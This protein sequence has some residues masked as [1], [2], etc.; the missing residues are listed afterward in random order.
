MIEKR[1]ILKLFLTAL[2]FAILINELNIAY[3][4]Y[5]NPANKNIGNA[6]LVHSSTVYSIDNSFYLPQIKNLIAGHGYTTDPKEPEMMVRRTPIYPLFYGSIYYLFGEKYCHFIIRYVQVLLFAVSAVL[7]FF[8]VYNL[9]HLKK[10]ALASAYLYAL[11]PFVASYCY[12]TLP[13]ALYPFLVVLSLF[14]FS[15]YFKTKKNQHLVYTGAAIGLAFLTKPTTGVLLIGVLAYLFISL[16]KNGNKILR[17]P[18]K[19][20]CF[21]VLIGSFFI[22]LLPWTIRNYKITQEIIVAEK[23]Y[24]NAPMN[25]GKAHI[26]LRFLTSCW[27]NPAN[28]STEVFSNRLI[29]NIKQNRIEQ[30]KQH[31]DEYISKWPQH[32][33]KGFNG[34]DLREAIHSLH[35]CF[36]EKEKF[37][38]EQ[39]RSLR[40][41]WL[42]LECEEIAFQKIN[43]LKNRFIKAAPLDYYVLTPI[44]TFKEIT[45]NS[46]LHHLAL[47]NYPRNQL[48]ALQFFAKGMAFL[49]NTMLMLSIIGFILFSKANLAKRMFLFCPFLALLFALIVFP[50][51]YVEVRYLLPVYPFLTITLAYFINK[52]PRQL[53]SRNNSLS[54]SK[55]INT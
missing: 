11:C 45:F 55:A 54:K 38:E 34:N 7:I 37:K 52:L 12:F 14:S 2:F 21:A 35:D 25:F 8:S 28:L 48:N 29:H 16:F 46:F 18:K 20:L 32:A 47:I 30:N 26:E 39:P 19:L 24:N 10:W 4:E 1:S 15:L 3:I 9:F 53:I 13:E 44:K 33:F 36:I 49:L 40:K 6:S 17:A 51:R 42:N 31:I 23:Y 22:I 5:V 41:E 50:F 27:T 43:D